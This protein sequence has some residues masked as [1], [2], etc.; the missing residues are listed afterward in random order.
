MEAIAEEV[1]PSFATLFWS[2]VSVLFYVTF[3]TLAVSDLQTPKAAYAK[4]VENLRQ[5]IHGIENNAEMVSRL[6]V[7]R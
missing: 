3:W 6:S 1:K 7:F 2:D 5:Q 4:Q